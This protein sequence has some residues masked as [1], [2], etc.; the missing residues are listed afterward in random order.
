MAG[1]KTGK[2][3]G[4]TTEQNTHVQQGSVSSRS[5]TQGHANSS[6]S[7]ENTTLKD[8][9]TKREA[10]QG[11]ENRNV[12]ASRTNEQTS[13]QNI[14]IKKDATNGSG[15]QLNDTTKPDPKGKEND[16]SDGMAKG[17][18]P[19]TSDRSVVGTTATP[20]PNL[21]TAFCTHSA[22]P[23]KMSDKT[24]RVSKNDRPTASSSRSNSTTVD[25]M[26]DK[27]NPQDPWFRGEMANLS[28]KAC[29]RP[30][31]DRSMPISSRLLSLSKSIAET[32]VQSAPRSMLTGR[33][34]NNVMED[35]TVAS[36]LSTKP[37]KKTCRG[38]KKKKPSTI[39]QE[40]AA[41]DSSSKSNASSRT[42]S[43]ALFRT[44]I[45]KKSMA[46]LAASVKPAAD[47]E[48]V[49]ID[50]KEQ[51]SKDNGV[52]SRAPSPVKRDEIESTKIAKAPKN[53]EPV[54]SDQSPA[55]GGREEEAFAGVGS[56][57]GPSFTNAVNKRNRPRPSKAEKCLNRQAAAQ[58]DFQGVKNNTQDIY[59]RPGSKDDTNDHSMISIA[60]IPSDDELGA[61]KIDEIFGRNDVPDSSKLECVRVI[62]MKQSQIIAR[63]TQLVNKYYK[64]NDELQ[65]RVGELDS[66]ILTQE[67]DNSEQ[68]AQIDKL[69]KTVDEFQRRLQNQESFIKIAEQDKSRLE[70]ELSSSSISLKSMEKERKALKESVSK[71]ENDVALMQND[72]AHLIGERNG[73]LA[74]ISNYESDRDMLLRQLQNGPTQE[75]NVR[76]Q[77]ELLEKNAELV[78]ANQ[79]FKDLQ[80]EYIALKTR[81]RKEQ[82]KR[83][84][85]SLSTELSLLG[86]EK[87]EEW[88]PDIDQSGVERN[89]FA[90]LPS[91]VTTPT[92]FQFGEL[93]TYGNWMER[94]ETRLNIP[95]TFL[96]QTDEETNNSES[97]MCLNAST[98]TEII[99][100]TLSSTPR[101]ELQ[102]S[103]ASTQT[104]AYMEL[105]THSSTQTNVAEMLEAST[106]T[107]AYVE[108]GTHN[109]TQMNAVEMFEAPAHTIAGAGA[110]ELGMLEASTQT[111][112]ELGV[113]RGTH[114]YDLDA[115]EASTQTEVGSKV[116]E[117]KMWEVSTQTDIATGVGGTKD[118][119]VQTEPVTVTQGSELARS[120][121]LVLIMFAWTAIILWGH[122]EDQR[123]WL[124]ANGVSRAA[125]VGMRDRSLGPFLWIEQL[126]YDLIAWLQVDRVLPG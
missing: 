70:E 1:K 31:T 46:T 14:S 53:E 52:R 121:R 76:L 44:D 2:P 49:D 19:I 123:L 37:K 111:V 87:E 80:R 124:D 108:L 5:Q 118:V 74:T 36:G 45:G 23:E 106:Q 55:K 94:N 27:A 18:A 73:F 119:M 16:Q 114:T 63:K 85:S 90:V 66:S 20:P 51:S 82:G 101:K 107:P 104:P 9:N 84:L 69:K 75:E 33:S 125:L 21:P 10:T 109:S 77:A 97:P 88:E 93:A 92:L 40:D 3:Y 99:L 71:T 26:G 41:T 35:A 59:E 115:L 43:G 61:E 102:L 56:G 58:S 116:H 25:R 32:N 11:K 122:T 91:P 15:N 89:P 50:I 42:K 79:N 12:H 30:A 112:C 83:T 62:M 39:D 34:A 4:N 8:D 105:G 22:R 113:S 103:E 96:H 24:A 48:K 81:G 65:E 47:V 28:A 68:Q 29:Q 120:L 86:D 17:N 60:D 54:S 110:Y 126:R 72:I 117:M 100:S 98:Q 64:E 7:N 38:R 6:R 13:D 78:I 95:K 57:Q 67:D